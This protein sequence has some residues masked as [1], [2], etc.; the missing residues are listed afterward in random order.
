MDEQNN[1]YIYNTRSKEQIALLK[2]QK[3]TL[4]AILFKDETRLF[5]AS[6]DNTVMMWKIK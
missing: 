6:D 2:G 3:S 1:I 4:N 5:S